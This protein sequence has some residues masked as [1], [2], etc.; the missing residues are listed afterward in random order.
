MTD[1]DEPAED[2]GDADP[3]DA[4]D[5]LDPFRARL[6]LLERIIDHIREHRDDRYKV[7]LALALGLI[8]AMRREQEEDAERFDRI[9]AAIDEL[10]A[11]T[12][13]GEED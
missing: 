2:F 4:W 13:T 10:Q 1:I 9:E 5:D 6:A 8:A 3:E 12:L 7:R 11:A